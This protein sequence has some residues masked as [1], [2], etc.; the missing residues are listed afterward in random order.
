MTKRTEQNGIVKD[1]KLSIIMEKAMELFAEKGYDGTSTAM[2]ASA[3]G[4]SKGLLYHYIGSKEN[5]VK[6]IVKEGYKKVSELFDLDH[7]GVLTGDEFEFFVRQSFRV[8]RGNNHFYQLL[9][10]LFSVPKIK[11]IME[12]EFLYLRIEKRMVEKLRDYFRSRFENPEKE[13]AAYYAMHEGLVALMLLNISNFD[14]V[15]VE[16]VI[17]K[18][19]EMF[20]R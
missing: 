5:L 3:S 18:I 12:D 10:S 11:N 4:I 14:D 19:I 8:V 1:E 2:I 6:V 9:A 16:N 13:F 20:K 17:E 7:N 15:F